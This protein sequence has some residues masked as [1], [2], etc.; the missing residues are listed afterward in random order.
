MI[1][2]I[3]K[4]TVMTAILA[5]SFASYA[6]DCVSHEVTDTYLSE[7]SLFQILPE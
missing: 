7:Y 3:L 2:T 5:L 1:R 6:T 4:V